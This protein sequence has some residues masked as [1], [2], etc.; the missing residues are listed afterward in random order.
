[1]IQQRHEIAALIGVEVPIPDLDFEGLKSFFD[2]WLKIHDIEEIKNPPIPSFEGVDHEKFSFEK[3]GE[4]HDNRM[5]C[6]DAVIQDLSPNCFASIRALFNF[7][8][9]SPYSEVFD[10]LLLVFRAEAGR[11]MRDPSQYK[12]DAMHLLDKTNAL[13]GVLNSLNF[14][15]RKDLMNSIFST[16]GLNDAKPRILESSEILKRRLIGHLA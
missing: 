16:Y 14:F 8:R 10:R 13:E 5:K 11:Y 12:K 2:N 15:G 1:M 7:H 6:R 9:E 4:W 3:M